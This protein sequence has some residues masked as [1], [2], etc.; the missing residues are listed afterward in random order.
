[1]DVNDLD[2]LLPDG[3]AHPL[4]H[5]TAN[6]CS[7]TGSST[8]IN[9]ELPQSL[10]ECQKRCSRI[11]KLPIF[12]HGRE[13]NLSPPGIC[14]L[15]PGKQ[16]PVNHDASNVGGPTSLSGS[17]GCLANLSLFRP[18][19]VFSLFPDETPSRTPP[20]FSFGRTIP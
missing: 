20:S 6:P 12:Q 16:L 5:I 4:H 8:K 19:S 2:A 11:R 15:Y 9:C 3:K 1:M 17:M 7:S 10:T 13:E 14:S 18:R